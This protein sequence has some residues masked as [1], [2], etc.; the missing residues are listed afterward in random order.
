MMMSYGDAVMMCV[1]D[2]SEK[3]SDLRVC[4]AGTCRFG[5]TCRE[6][7]ADIKCVCQFH[8]SHTPHTAPPTGCSTHYSSYVVV[9]LVSIVLCLYFRKT[10]ITAIGLTKYVIYLKGLEIHVL[11]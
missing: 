7:G 10:V 6:N 9:G 11:Q 8:V 3:K 1:A 4:D 2:L 5:G